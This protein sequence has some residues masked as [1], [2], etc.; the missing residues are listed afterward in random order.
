[1]DLATFRRLL[2]PDGQAALAAAVELRPSTATLLAVHQ[3]LRKQFPD[4]LAR[5]AVETA[6]LRQKAKA[7]F[8]RADQMYFTR[9][10]LEQSSGETISAYR[11]RRFDG[12]ERIGD[13]CCGI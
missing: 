9:A 11:A 5:A 3:R 13:W 8:T 4:E 2:M 12:F 10:A 1:M 7:K 6:L